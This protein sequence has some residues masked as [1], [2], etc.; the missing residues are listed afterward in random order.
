[1]GTR[2]LL[3]KVLGALPEERLRQL[4]DFAEFLRL[5]EEQ[6]EWSQGGMASLAELYGSEE[7]EYTEADIK[8]ELNR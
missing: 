5:L 7:P 1:M 4:L 2:Q 3:D 6:K 8:P